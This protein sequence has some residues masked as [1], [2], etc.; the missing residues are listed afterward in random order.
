MPANPGQIEAVER[1]D[2]ML[3]EAMVRLD[4][5]ENNRALT[6]A[7][8]AI[9]LY[10]AIMLAREPDPIHIIEYPATGASFASFPPP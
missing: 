10:L 9:G 7:A 4:H 5:G 2:K 3:S 8:T 6:C 1:A